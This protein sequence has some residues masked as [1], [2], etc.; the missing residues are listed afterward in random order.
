M[1]SNIPYISRE[2]TDAIFTSF[3]KAIK[4]PATNPLVFNVW[5]IGGVGK[6][7]LLNELEQQPKISFARVFFGSTQ[8]IATPLKL[9]ANLYRQLPAIDDWGEE[10]ETFTDLYQ[11]FEKTLQDLEKPDTKEGDAK[12][13]ERKEAIKKLVGASAKT[14]TK[15]I[16]VVKDISGAEDKI[17]LIAEG[18]VDLV[19]WLQ[20]QKATKRN[21]ELQALMLK[22]IPRLTEALIRG[23]IAKS[24]QQPVV[25]LLDTYEKANSEIDDW[26]WQYLIANSQLQSH[27]IRIVVA[28][29]NNLLKKESWRK[30][31][32]DFNSVY[33]LEI[34]RFNLEQT[35][36]YLGNIGISE[37]E[38]IYH[39]TKGLPYYL[40]W[41]REQKEKGQKLD[42]SQG[43]QE[44]ANLLLQ[45][46]DS[47]QQEIIKLAACCR[48]FDQALIEDLTTNPKLEI[49]NVVDTQLDCFE[50][51]TQLDFVELF[52]H[53]YR[54]DDVARDVFR[55]SLWQE[56]RKQFC[57]VHYVLACYFE[58]KANAEVPA[59]SSPR[60]QYENGEWREYTGEFLYHY[61][62]AKQQDSEKKFLSHLFESCYF[63]TTE[64]IS[65]PF[66]A[67]IAEA[68]L[69]NYLLLSDAIKKFLL[70][71]QLIVNVN[72]LAFE[73]QKLASLLTQTEIKSSV[74]SLA[75]LAKFAA[76]LYTAKNCPQ[77]QQLKYLKL[78]QSQAETIIIEADLEFSSGLFVWD[79]GNSLLKFKHYEEAVTSYD[80]A[81]NINPEDDSAWSNRGVALDILKRYEEVVTSFD[82]A[83]D[84]NPE[85]DSAWSNRGVALGNL[86]RYEEAVTSFDRALKI[87]P[88]NDSAWSNRGVALAN[89]ERYEEAVTSY[90]RA[91][92]INP[93]DDSAWYNLACCFALQNQIESVLENLTKAIALNPKY[94]EIAKTDAD[95][96]K[97]R[98]NSR[99]KKLIE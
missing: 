32:Q 23:L 46:L 51:L 95:F 68:Y 59:D 50:W 63:Q 53:S 40:N 80:R 36:A 64:V 37:S 86:E 55:L 73:E 67:I 56:N 9:M 79:I 33:S 97:I 66:N 83:L 26:L 30:L 74:E 57:Q 47:K 65:I 12:T 7:R 29:R 5:G 89:L 96:D 62:F 21:K 82:R 98:N 38:E 76:L 91:L 10:S 71:I 42:F 69:E 49:V 15:I 16:P 88:E 24:Q 87:N 60:L 81:L 61:L 27:P 54:L 90:D 44:I 58:Q 75:G 3:T 19:D 85:D 1:T 4:T 39:V 84:I 78:A 25:L 22:P 72:Y 18:G 34:E 17:G 70:T 8:D 11:Q 14:F 43:N 6:T 77:S 35:Q 48:W 45:G 13:T 20:K 2:Q 28:G 99:F 92:K 94:R 31:Q 52:Q 93:E 41:I